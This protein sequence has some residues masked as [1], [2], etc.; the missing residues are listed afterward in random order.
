VEDPNIQV[1]IA[2]DSLKVGN[3]FPNVADVVVLNPKDPSNIVQKTGCAGQTSGCVGKNRG[4]NI[5]VH[6]VTMFRFTIDHASSEGHI[7]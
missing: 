4:Q 1:L 6:G 5:T 7:E 2:T 3:D